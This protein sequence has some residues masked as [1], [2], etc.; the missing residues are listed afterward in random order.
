MISEQWIWGWDNNFFADQL[1]AFSSGVIEN[2][3]TKQ[4]S[5]NK[6]ESLQQ[7][8]LEI[9]NWTMN[10]CR[11]QKNIYIQVSTE[12]AQSTGTDKNYY[13]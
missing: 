9:K 13:Q 7:P 5:E 12:E 4:T 10:I 6:G 8:H 2:E 11:I 1:E 3:I